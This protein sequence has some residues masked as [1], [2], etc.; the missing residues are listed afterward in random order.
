MKEIGIAL[1]LF[2]TLWFL[3]YYVY[4]K[5]ILPIILDNYAMQE[6]DRNPNWII[7]QLQYHGFD[8]IDIVLY[9]SNYHTAIQF[10]ER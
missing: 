2:A 9:T 7:S 4:S 8:D 3:Y 5:L 6:V 10:K 1:I